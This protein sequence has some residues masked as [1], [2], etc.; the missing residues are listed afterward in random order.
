MPDRPEIVPP[1]LQLVLTGHWLSPAATMR[2]RITFLHKP[3]DGI[4]PATLKVTDGSLSGPVLPAVREDRITLALDEL[5]DELR[6]LLQNCHE[7]HIRWVTP[8]PYD[9]VSPLFSRLAPGFHLFYTPGSH[10]VPQ[11]QLCAVLREIFGPVD[12]KTAEASFT[13]LPN[14]RFSHSTAYQYFQPLESLS[15]FITYAKTTIC[16][17]V[18][19]TD[20]K[21]S[22]CAARVDSLATASTLDIS[23]DTISH[24]LKATASWPHADQ[25]LSITTT[26]SADTHRVEVGVLTAG[27]DYPNLEPHEIGMAGVLTVLGQD[28][29]PSATMFSFPA[30]HRRIEGGAFTTSLAGPTGLHPVLRMQMNA[31]A[32]TPPPPTGEG[33]EC[34]LHAYFTLP[35]TLFADKYQLADELFLGS[36]NLSALRYMSQPVDLEAPEY[37]MDQWGSAVLLELSPPTTR[38]QEPSW[39][40]E[41]P[42]HLRYLAPSSGGYASIEV[43]YPVVFW[44]CTTEEGTKFP[45]SPFERVNLG[46]DGLFGPRTV[47]WHVKPQPVKAGGRLTTRIRAPVLDTDKA[48]WVSAGTAAAVMLGFGWIVWKL[49]EV[50]LKTGYGPKQQMDGLEKKKKL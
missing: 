50:Y 32:S 17:S 16:P 31:K 10:S 49:L 45:A 6:Q 25:A 47:F 23:Y 48:G 3:Q 37:V 27:D 21:D 29:K 41:V 9:T 24:A 7:L 11:D 14:A 26:P 12:C 40:A 33:G 22:P 5:P 4:D 8:D 42:L 28:K 2:Q 18:S 30:R 15:P 44:A 36:K 1:A 39:T 19:P 34:A 38:L 13:T 46:Y 20:P 43:P 35:R